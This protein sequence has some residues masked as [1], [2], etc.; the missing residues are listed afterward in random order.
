MSMAM[1]VY[2]VVYPNKLLPFNLTLISNILG[3][4]F[5]QHSRMTA[6]MAHPGIFL[7]VPIS[8]S[9]SF[10]VFIQL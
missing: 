3:T 9:F 8:F 1:T 4:K 7:P 10:T 5:L 6:S 2:Q